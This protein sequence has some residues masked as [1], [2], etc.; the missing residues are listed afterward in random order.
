MENTGPTIQEHGAEELD[1]IIGINLKGVYFGLTHAPRHMRDGGSI[2]N[3][4]SAAALLGL[5]GYSQYAMTKAAVISLTKTAAI[6]LSAR[7]IRVNA[8][9]P[10]SVRTAML[11]DGHPEIAVV[12]VLAPL[13]RIAETDELVGIYHFLASEESR[14]MTGQA[15][16]ID[17][18][19]TAG[20]S[21]ALLAR[22]LPT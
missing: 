14:Y 12:E 8:V 17:G 15:I 13:G 20:P 5:Y 22:C 2:I 3:T 4:S 1:H 7:G 10:G 19:V 16:V 18:G 11:P 21:V 9:C 6:E